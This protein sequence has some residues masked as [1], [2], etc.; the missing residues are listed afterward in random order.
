MFINQNVH[1]LHNKTKPTSDTETEFDD[2]DK[3]SVT[4]RGS[5]CEYV[6]IKSEI[7]QF[8]NGNHIKTDGLINK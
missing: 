5:Q 7:N 6:Y 3:I 2:K 4:P 8:R 1:K